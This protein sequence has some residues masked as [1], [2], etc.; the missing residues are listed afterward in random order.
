M[1]CHISLR[2]RWLLPG[3]LI[4]MNNGAAIPTLSLGGRQKCLAKVYTLTRK[5][6]PKSAYIFVPIDNE[7]LPFLDSFSNFLTEE[8]GC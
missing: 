4:A 5:R 6:K 1:V 3:Q 2:N 7:H 8:P